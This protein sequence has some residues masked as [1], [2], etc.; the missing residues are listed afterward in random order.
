MIDKI[1]DDTKEE[2]AI[3]ILNVN[4]FIKEGGSRCI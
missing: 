4:S 3:K 2:L 1:I